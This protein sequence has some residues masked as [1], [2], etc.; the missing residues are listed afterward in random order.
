MRDHNYFVYITTNPQRQF[1]IQAL[2]IIW[3]FALNNIT[4]TEER[5]TPLQ[6]NTTAISLSTMKGS[7]TSIRP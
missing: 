4:A 2:Q 3:Q 5:K 6:V 7:L 1:Y